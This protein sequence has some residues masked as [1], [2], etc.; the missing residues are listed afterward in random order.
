MAATL[1]IST[2]EN[3][4]KLKS[5]LR[6][7]KTSRQHKHI[8]IIVRTSQTSKLRLPAQSRTD[9]LMLIQSHADTI[10]RTADSDT[11]AAAARLNSDRTRM[12]EISIITTIGTESTEILIRYT[13]SL[14]ITLHNRLEFKPGMIAA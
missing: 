13:L 4:H 6:S 3:I 1:E 11:R 7:D 12:R 5:K 2:Q 10:A 9:T 14:E 8:S